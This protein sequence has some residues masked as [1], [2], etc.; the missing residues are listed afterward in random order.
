MNSSVNLKRVLREG[1][2]K[3]KIPAYKKEWGLFFRDFLV[4]ENSEV[5]D[6]SGF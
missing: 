1:K 4:F 2:A 6:S 3:K 5:L